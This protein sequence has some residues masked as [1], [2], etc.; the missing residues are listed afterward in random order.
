MPALGLKLF[1]ILA[2][3]GSDLAIK[4]ALDYH[5]FYSDESTCANNMPRVIT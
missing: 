2:L 1:S 4:L 5:Q 3:L